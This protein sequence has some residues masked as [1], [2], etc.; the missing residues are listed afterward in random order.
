MNKSK[1]WATGMLLAVF[2]AGLV[3]GSAVNALADRSV[4]EDRPERRSYTDYL[5]EELELSA[6]QRDGVVAVLEARR[7]AIR[8]IWDVTQPRYDMIRQETRT[9][10]M[11][12]LD[13]PQQEVYEG[14]IA[15][16]DSVRASRRNKKH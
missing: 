10:I 7:A 3:A 13:E 2:A 1:A 6:E 8:Q 11:Q 9:E 12:L 16:S 15:H 14:M 4:P 5:H